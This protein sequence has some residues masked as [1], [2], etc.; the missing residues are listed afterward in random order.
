[1][2]YSEAYSQMIAIGETVTTSTDEQGQYS[3]DVKGVVV[4]VGGD[5]GW[6]V[7]FDRDD[8]TTPWEAITG[9]SDYDDDVEVTPSWQ[10]TVS[11]LVAFLGNPTGVPETHSAAFDDAAGQALG[12]LP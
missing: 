7:W 10:G 5:L 3:A 2:T 4:G 12:V 1:M 8:R 6:I 9:I 11:E